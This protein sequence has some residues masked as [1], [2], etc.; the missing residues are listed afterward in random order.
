MTSP[1]WT[2]TEG[3]GPLLA[4]AIHAGHDLRPEL[5][6]LVALSDAGRLREEAPFTDRVA[7]LAPTRLVVHRSRFEVDLNRSRDQAVYLRPEDAWGLAVWRDPLPEAVRR[8]SLDLYDRFYA[9]FRA[10]LERKLAVHPAL[11]VLDL[12]SSNHRRAGPGAPPDDPGANPEVNLG[13]GSLDRGRFGPVADAF[14]AALGT[15]QREG[16]PLDVRENV[17]FRGGHLGRWAHEA[18]P[19]NARFPRCC[20]R[21]RFVLDPP[22]RLFLYFR[23]KS[24]WGELWRSRRR[25]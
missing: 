19:W 11:L 16:R 21:W 25:R 15:E 2:L 20:G 22:S 17:R 8:R 6:P 5:E 10:L 7:A 9:A 3:D 23:R 1:P 4:L 13:T 14:L 18:F 12:H 24:P